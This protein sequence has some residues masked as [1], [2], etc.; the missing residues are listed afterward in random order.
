MRKSN[1]IIVFAAILLLFLTTC[2]SA[3]AGAPSLVQ[4]KKFRAYEN[5]IYDFIEHGLKPLENKD[6]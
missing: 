1:K 5:E 4:K 6:T 3:F 2:S